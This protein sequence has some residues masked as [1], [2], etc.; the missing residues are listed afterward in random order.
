M[1]RMVRRLA[2]ACIVKGVTIR[3]RPRVH[4]IPLR[5]GRLPGLQVKG[6]HIDRVNGTLV[7]FCLR[8]RIPHLETARRNEDKTLRHGRRHLGHHP[9]KTQG[10]DNADFHRP[11][12]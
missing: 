8:E 12:T 7:D 1:H 6:R 10:P 5:L 11:I 2:G 9:V 4:G 3:Q